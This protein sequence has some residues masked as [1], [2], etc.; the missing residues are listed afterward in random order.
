M[1]QLTLIEPDRASGRSKEHLDGVQAQMGAVPNMFRVMANAPV[2]LD[3][4]LS[5]SASLSRGALP[6]RF[7]EQLAILTASRNGCGY[8]LA[9]HTMLGE[10]AGLSSEDSVGARTAQVSDPREEAGLRFA[11]SLIDSKGSVSEADI[12]QARDAGYTDEEISEIIG[13]VALNTFSNM[14]NNATQPALDFPPVDA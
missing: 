4:Y 12:R 10:N 14:Y 5:F 2:V 6:S 8:C 11:V 13:H 7:R 1:T 9:A 3:A